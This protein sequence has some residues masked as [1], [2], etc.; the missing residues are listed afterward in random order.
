VR[1]NC[2][3]PT[4]PPNGPAFTVFLAGLNGG[5]FA[6]HHDWFLPTSAGTYVGDPP[7]FFPTGQ[8]AQ[9]ESIQD[10]SICDPSVDQPCVYQAFNTNCD[11]RTGNPGCTIDGAGGTAECSCT[12]NGCPFDTCLAAGYD[13]S[14]PCAD[15]ASNCVLGMDYFGGYPERLT[16]G[17]P[18]YVR[19]VRGG[20]TANCKPTTCAAQGAACGSI[21][22]GCNGMYGSGGTIDCGGCTAPD[23]CGGGGVANQCGCADNGLACSNAGQVC[24][25][26]VDNCGQEVSCGTCPSDRPKCCFESCVESTMQCP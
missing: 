26:H 2:A 10:L 14:S 11:W 24:G 6:G 21:P 18:E 12:A 13:S 8:A 7:V 1:P 5:G 23:T 25:T 22:D 3:D 17:Y 20:S 4:C 9:I 19:A 16:Q 15:G